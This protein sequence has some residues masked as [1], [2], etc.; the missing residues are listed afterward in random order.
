M[1][2]IPLFLLL[3]FPLVPHTPPLVFTTNVITVQTYKTLRSLH[4]SF[5]LCSVCAHHYL[6]LIL[7]C[8]RFYDTKLLGFLST[9]WISPWNLWYPFFLPYPAS[10]KKKKI[11]DLWGL[12]LSPCFLDSVS[13]PRI[14]FLFSA[15]SQQLWT[16][17]PENSLPTGHLYFKFNMSQSWTL[18][19]LL[20]NWLLLLAFTILIYC[21]IIHHTP[22]SAESVTWEWSQTPHGPSFPHQSSHQALEIKPLEEIRNLS[23]PSHPHCYCHRLGLHWVWTGCCLSLWQLLTN[24]SITLN[25]RSTLSQESSLSFFFYI[26]K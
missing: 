5:F 18:H 26:I 15:N 10:K 21:T 20:P 9:S 4:I 17:I 22:P 14:S 12:L 8:L 23:A 7:S 11:N 3:H 1:H 2:F 19:L 13:F 24:I 25:F 16:Q 6:F